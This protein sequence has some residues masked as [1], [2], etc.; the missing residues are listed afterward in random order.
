MNPANGNFAL[1]K[2][3]VSHLY[4]VDA[5]TLPGISREHGRGS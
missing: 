2:T 1:A 5:H 4:W 3:L